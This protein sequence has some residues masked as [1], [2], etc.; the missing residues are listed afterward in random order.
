[1]SHSN[2]FDLNVAVVALLVLSMLFVN[3]E[4]L[5]CL[6]NIYPSLSFSTSLSFFI[7]LSSLFLT[8]FHVSFPFSLFHF[9]SL[10]FFSLNLSFSLLFSSRSF[11]LFLSLFLNISILFALF[12][13]S[14]LLSLSLPLP[15]YLSLSSLNAFVLFCLFKPEQAIV[16]FIA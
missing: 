13:T 11:P 15:F 1:M 4:I 14:F 9:L 5:R 8:L 12:P 7:S 3:L 6:H 10:S 2:L 16:R